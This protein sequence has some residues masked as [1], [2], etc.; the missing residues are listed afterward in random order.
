MARIEKNNIDALFDHEV[1]WLDNNSGPAGD[2]AISSRIR[3]ARNIANMPFPAVA[4][5]H[6]MSQV[7]QLVE[8]AWARSFEHDE[9]FFIYEMES[10]SELNRQLL[11]ERRLVSHEFIA[12]P[13][14]RILAVNND[15]SRAVMINEEDH[16]HIQ[17]LAPGLQ[18]DSVWRE[19]NEL[20]NQLSGYIPYAF[21]KKLGFLTSCLTNLG[22]GL[23]ASV[24]LHLPGLVWT[25]KIE[26]TMQGVVKLGFAVRGIFDEGD[27]N[28]GNLFQISNQSTLGERE[29]QI[30]FRLMQLIKPLIAHEKN[31]R[32]YLLAKNRYFL[33]DNIGRAYGLLR[34][35]YMLSYAET[36]DALSALRVGVDLGMF[37][38][39]S[40]KTVN[41]LF[42]IVQPA[43]LQRFAGRKLKREERHIFRAEVVRKLLGENGN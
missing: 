24:I 26:P 1:K 38:S 35:A 12:V 13:G 5:L 11:L 16:L 33:L 27:D 23:R 31:A 18:L 17:L 6:D 30:I 10:L 20:D 37:S 2:I 7:A 14:G 22:T 40:L 41:K 21:D 25:G 15:E 32:Q 3:L 42:K 9:K 8:H 43:H 28:R 34:R 36:L 4:S 29:D 19:I 39:V